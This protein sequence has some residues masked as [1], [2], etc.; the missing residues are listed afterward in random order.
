MTTD[1]RRTGLE[2]NIHGSRD[3]A[4]VTKHPGG[5]GG[6]AGDV[7]LSAT[8]G[9]CGCGVYTGDEADAGHKHLE[10]HR[11]RRLGDGDGES[12]LGRIS[13]GM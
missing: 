2:G 8:R 11:M 7:N 5:V 12:E 10:W 3:Q 4:G 1:D 13:S 6:S 9:E